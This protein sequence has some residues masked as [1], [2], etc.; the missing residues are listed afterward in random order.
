MRK[1]GVHG[2]HSITSDK[3]SKSITCKQ[4][5]KVM[6][7]P[8]PFVAEGKHSILPNIQTRRPQ[9]FETNHNTHVAIFQWLIA[10]QV[11]LHMDLKLII[12]I[13]GG[14]LCWLACLHSWRVRFLHSPS[15]D[16]FHVVVVPSRVPVCLWIKVAAFETLGKNWNIA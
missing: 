2:T 11:F 10:L 3:Y 7:R 5:A 15:V 6:Y 1:I 4:N 16:F 9:I 12:V 8:M 14:S 13:L